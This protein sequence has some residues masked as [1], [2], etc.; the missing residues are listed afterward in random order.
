MQAGAGDPGESEWSMRVQGVIEPRG[1]TL[2]LCMSC[3]YACH[4]G[5]CACSVYFACARV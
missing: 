1:Y 2:C 5:L 4:V 3:M